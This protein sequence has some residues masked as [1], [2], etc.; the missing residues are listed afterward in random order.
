[1]LSAVLLDVAIGAASA[2]GHG[3]QQ[4]LPSV[5]PSVLP[6]VLPSGP[7]EGNT[8]YV[9]RDDNCR[10]RPGQQA[11]RTAIIFF[12]MIR[13]ISASF[14]GLEEHAL[15]PL[16]RRGGV[17]VHVH[18]MHG[19][20]TVPAH[21][22]HDS[23]LAPWPADDIE[24]LSPCSYAIATQSRVDAEQQFAERIRATYLHSTVGVA[25]YYDTPT[26]FNLFRSTYSLSR[27]GLLVEARENRTGVR[28]EQVVIL[29]PDATFLAP[30]AWDALRAGT[31]ALL[32]PNHAHWLGANDRF[33]FGDRDS[34]G[35]YWREYDEH[36]R[37]ALTN[38]AIVDF[39]WSEDLMC[40]HLVAKPLPALAIGVLPTCLVRV[41]SNGSLTLSEFQ[42]PRRQ[43]ECPGLLKLD[44]FANL[45]NACPQP[46]PRDAICSM[47]CYEMLTN[48]AEKESVLLDSERC[49]I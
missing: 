47:R 31:R 39:G 13:N 48:P 18:A 6:S 1:M 49:C 23:P 24:R 14:D 2:A 15:K 25:T 38:G 28:Y 3:G 42:D 16:R 36:M 9:Y 32:V 19:D 10:V 40:R 11:P 37:G 30:V 4:L 35:W 5:I 46:P 21:S 17:D 34:V 44:N 27:A 33:A 43:V 29:R 22:S 45:T 26:M 8:S 20:S 12:G 7:G 41:R